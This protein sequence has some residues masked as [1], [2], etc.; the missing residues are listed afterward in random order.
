MHICMH[1]HTHAHT[2]SHTVTHTHTS[3]QVSKMMHHLNSWK[4]ANCTLY[5]GM[6]SAMCMCVMSL[7]SCPV[8]CHWRVVMCVSLKS[9]HVCDVTEELSCVW[10]HWRV[11]WVS[12]CSVVCVC[13]T[14]LK[15]CV[16]VMSLKSCPVCDVI[17]E[18]S[19]VWCHWRVVMYISLKSCHVCDVTEELSC[20]W[21]HWRVL[22]VSHCRVVCVC[23]W[24]HWRSVCV[25]HHWRSV[26][27]WCHW[28]VLCACCHQYCEF[29]L[30]V[31]AVFFLYI[32]FIATPPELDRKFLFFHCCASGEIL[33]FFLSFFLFFSPFCHCS[34]TCCGWPPPPPISMHWVSHS[35]LR[36]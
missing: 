29:W 5:T 7:K 27:V 8:W 22:W 10:C 23:V 9:C 19:C 36:P 25:W 16:C 2:H 32:F 11:L 14:S 17:E 3:H 33:S 18:L 12:H 24:H 6:V 15:I 20:V 28:L 31:H 34:R 4:S 35:T 13:V 1:S 21:C 30:G 26:C